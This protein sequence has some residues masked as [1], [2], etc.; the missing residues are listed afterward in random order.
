MQIKGREILHMEEPAHFQ[1][2]IIRGYRQKL[3]VHMLTGQQ[4]LGL[5]VILEVNVL[6]SEPLIKFPVWRRGGRRFQQEKAETQIK[7]EEQ[8]L[9][10]PRSSVCSRAKQSFGHR[11]HRESRTLRIGTFHKQKQLWNGYCIGQHLGAPVLRI[12]LEWLWG[13]LTEL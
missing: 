5:A 4:G 10:K 6:S 2:S 8:A 11:G 7:V 3:S 9:K 13:L 12:R 1:F